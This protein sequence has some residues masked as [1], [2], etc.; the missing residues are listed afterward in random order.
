MGRK[1]T[2]KY[3]RHE[4]VPENHRSSRRFDSTFGVLKSAYGS[5]REQP[6][7]MESSSRVKPSDDTPGRPSRR[8]SGGEI[9]PIDELEQIEGHGNLHEAIR[10]INDTEGRTYTTEYQ[11]R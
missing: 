10:F 2:R 3:T 4:T 11:R 1:K 7:V 6:R 8:M 5:T 9:E